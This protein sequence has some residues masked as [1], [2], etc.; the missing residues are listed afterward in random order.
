MAHARV[1]EQR[2][3]SQSILSPREREVAE[4]IARGSTNRE[5]ARTLH[6]A[7]GTARR[8]VSNI[9][10]RLDFHSRAQIASWLSGGR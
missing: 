7:D 1:E 3:I 9:L 10:A 5:I 6:I 4:L 2:S 8:H